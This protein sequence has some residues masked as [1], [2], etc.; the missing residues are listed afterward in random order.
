MSVPI[1][2]FIAFNKAGIVA[3]DLQTLLDTSEDFEL[4]I[5]DNGSKD[6]TWKFIET[7]EDKRIK[8]K[9]RFDVNRGCV[10]ALNYILS[11]RKPGQYFVHIDSDMYL[12]TD[13]WFQTFLEAF[14]LFPELGIVGATTYKE[15]QGEET[16]YKLTTK[17][18]L[19]LYKLSGIM[20][21]FMCIRPEVFDLLGYFCE[22]TCGADT[23]IAKRVRLFTPYGIG[24]IPS[25]KIEQKYVTC[26]ECKMQHLCS[27][28]AKEECYRLW[29]SKYMHGPF[30]QEVIIPKSEIFYKQI[31]E[32][33]RTP[34]CASIHDE[35]SMKNHYY[36]KA[37][38]EENFNFFVE[39]AN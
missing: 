33:K 35:E 2:S 37:S 6:D 10:Y 3:R 12:H 32:G 19:S 23:D 11:H 20:G 7:L 14:R 5:V 38:A 31:E 39:R 13:K 25:I 4:Y 9:K 29:R 22:E 16:K 30:Y 8:E 24:A 27:Y 28:K 17:E 26:Q 21:C 15:L 34:Y 18:G 1:V 36:D